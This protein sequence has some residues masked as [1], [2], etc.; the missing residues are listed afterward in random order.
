MTA[1]AEREIH[2]DPHWDPL[3]V[4]NGRKP[5]RR[6]FDLRTS[7]LDLSEWGDWRQAISVL[8]LGL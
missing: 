2:T 3:A 1:A 7:K 4:A 6:R 5:S 8:S